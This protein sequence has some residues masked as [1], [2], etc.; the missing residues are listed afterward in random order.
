MID[1]AVQPLLDGFVTSVRAVAEV[2]AVWLHG[3][4]ALGDYQ[5]GRSDLDVIVVVSEPPPPSVAEVHRELIRSNPL[6]VKLHCSYM[7]DLADLSVRHPTFAHQRYFDRPVTPVTRRELAIG[8]RSLFGPVPGELLPPVSD[9]ELFAFVRRDLRDFWYP[10][11]RKRTPWYRDIWVDL[12]LLTLARAHV[13]LATGDLITK[14]AALDVLPRL[15]APVGVVE[16]IRRR[17]YEPE[18]RVG[19]WWRHTRAGLTRR[20]LRT[21]IPT[22]LS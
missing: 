6:A 21:A 2:R 22:V 5:L 17:R 1:E 16:D 3:S 4:L 15:G 13:T 14:R 10:V 12:S 19:P 11:T 20:F 7:T 18:S 9:E 8:N